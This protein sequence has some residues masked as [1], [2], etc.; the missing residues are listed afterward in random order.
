[1]DYIGVSMRM[2]NDLE[3]DFGIRFKISG[4]VNKSGLPRYLTSGR[5]IYKAQYED[6]KFFIIKLF[7]PVDSRVLSKEL[8]IYEDHY[9]APIVFWFDELT[10]NNRTAYIKHHIPFVMLPTQIYLP[11]LGV[12][13]SKKFSGSK[14]K[15]YLPLSSNAQKILL[16]LLYSDTGENIK[17]KI[18]EELCLDPVYVTRGTKELVSRKYASEAKSGR[19]TVVKRES[20]S[21]ELFE[22]SRPS[23]VSPVNRVIYAKKTKYALALPMAGDYALSEISMLNPPKIKTYACYKKDEALNKLDIVDEPE[24]EDSDKICRIEL[25]N[26]DP[27]QLSDNDMVD[28]ISLY[29]SLMGSKDARVQK[30]LDSMLEELKWQ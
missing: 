5:E 11:F 14:R 29:C 30:E 3:N 10:K 21:K 28:A 7:Q 13:F 18:A 16:Y 20:G 15:D 26:Y 8:V 27:V 4:D 6:Y 23:L 25:W 9:G 12:L 24:W 2:E 19:Y 17:R 22:K 1:M